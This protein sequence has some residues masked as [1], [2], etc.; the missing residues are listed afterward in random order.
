M[1]KPNDFQIEF[2]WRSIVDSEA[3]KKN[4][5]YPWNITKPSCLE[6]GKICDIS[7]TSNSSRA[8]VKPKLDFVKAPNTAR[9]QE[10]MRKIEIKGQRFETLVETERLPSSKTALSKKA[11]LYNSKF[12]RTSPLKK[13]HFD[14]ENLSILPSKYLDFTQ[15]NSQMLSNANLSALRCFLSSLNLKSID[16]NE[17]LSSRINHINLKHGDQAGNLCQYIFKN[18]R[19]ELSS[20]QIS[21]IEVEENSFNESTESEKFLKE[22]TKEVKY[23]SNIDLDLTVDSSPKVISKSPEYRNLSSALDKFLSGVSQVEEE[24]KGLKRAAYGKSTFN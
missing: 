14:K 10:S 1:G 9:F 3:Q 4:H 23:E 5:S 19:S 2:R 21:R 18:I 7:Y 6:K 12:E 22:I 11:D 20:E 24:L 16:D 13:E 8:T 15:E 17:F